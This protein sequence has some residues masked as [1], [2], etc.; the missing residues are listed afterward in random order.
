MNQS[1]NLPLGDLGATG[2]FDGCPVWMVLGWLAP[3]FQDGSTQYVG[4][5]DPTSSVIKT[6]WD[7][8]LALPV[9]PGI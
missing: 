4:L 9:T 5:L 2:Y 8:E 7:A 1:C 3:N 6:A